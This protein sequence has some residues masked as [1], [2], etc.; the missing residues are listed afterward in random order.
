M[1][2]QVTQMDSARKRALLR[3]R[4]NKVIVYALLIFFAIIFLIPVAWMLSTALKSLADVSAFPPVIIPNPPL[5]SNFVTALTAVPVFQYMGNSAAYC[6]LTIIGDILSSS[7]VAYAFAHV[8]FKYREI[9]FIFVL[10]TMMIP[11]EVLIIPQFLLFRSLGWI[12]T[13]LPLIVPTFFGSPYLIFLLRQAFR[14]ISRD[15]VE[16]AKLDGANHLVI[17]WRIIL[18]LSRPA[19]AAVAIFSF[20]FHWNDLMGPLIYLNTNES[21]PI[22]LGLSQYTAA[23]GT[24]AWNIL[25]AAALVAVIPC[26]LVFFFSQRYIIQGIVVARPSVEKQ[27]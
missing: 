12:D 19:L 23:Y 1:S 4:I 8:R 22:S 7:L 17:W 18:P 14:G 3:K 15:V 20:M 9:V 2:L 25:M 11:Y 21:Y 26:V 5:W 27:Q 24:T 13:Y 16:A 6:L 10:A